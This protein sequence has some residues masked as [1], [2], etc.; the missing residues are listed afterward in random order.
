MSFFSVLL[1]QGESKKG[2]ADIKVD[3]NRTLV[4]IILYDV[5]KNC[6]YNIKFLIG[7]YGKYGIK[8]GYIVTDS[9]GNFNNTIRFNRENNETG[10]NSFD[11]ISVI[12]LTPQNHNENE[13][14]ILGFKGDKYEFENMDSVEIEDLVD[15]EYVQ[16]KDYD[17]IVDNSPEYWPFSTRINGL[18]T[19]KI[20]EN[21][22]KKLNL[23][24]IKD[25]IKDY[26]LNSLKFYHFLILGRCVRGKRIVYILGI[27]DKFNDCQVISM[28]NMGAKKFYSIDMTKVPRNGDLGFWVIFI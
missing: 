7:K 10:V 8:K 11:N 16:N 13:F 26:A 5:L 20:D 21:I 22:F 19:V 18:K 1:F 3:E 9:S 12:V 6:K 23:V 27:P 14:K 4:H 15:D 25:S 2:R 28:A 24:C 17:A